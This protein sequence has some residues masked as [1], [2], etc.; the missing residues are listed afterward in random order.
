MK[1]WAVLTLSV[2]LAGCDFG[3]SLQ[4]N[5]RNL[6]DAIDHCRSYT[7]H[8]VIA[9]TV[10][11]VDQLSTRQSRDFYEVYLNLDTK[12][13]HGYSYCQI[14]MDG[15]IVQHSAPGFR[16]NSGAFSQF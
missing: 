6:G 4:G 10:I 5:V 13:K 12:E 7:R 15:L 9:D 1:R 8:V 16:K 11:S 3:A 2:L 14:D